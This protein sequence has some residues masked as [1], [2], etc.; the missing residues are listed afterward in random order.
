MTMARVATLRGKWKQQAALPHCDHRYLELEGIALGDLADNYYCIVC[1]KCV[2]R[3][4]YG[5]PFT[6]TRPLPPAKLG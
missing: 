2:V 5:F 4:H 6:L 1:G 3:N